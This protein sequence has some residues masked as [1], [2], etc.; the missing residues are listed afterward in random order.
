MYLDLAELDQVFANRWLW[1]AR[2]PAV[3]WFRR[4]DHLGERSTTLDESV[5]QFVET[6]TG[7]RPT[8]P[9]RLLTHLRTFGYVIN[10]ISFYYCFDA[11]GQQ[12]R[13]IVAQVDNTPWGERHCYV[14][15]EANSTTTG[16]QRLHRQTKEFHV[17]PFM[18]M[19]I[20]Y[21]WRLTMPGRQ[22]TAH[23]ENFS[24]GEKL[25][26]AT[27]LLKRREITGFN[28]ARVFCRFPL[29][30]G[31]VVAAIYWQALRLWWK[32]CPYFP[33]PKSSTKN[34]RVNP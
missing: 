13:T 23:I 27:L 32:K 2:G 31:Q 22:L 7:R 12:V 20:E 8:G 19:E 34:E 29:M 18:P 14:L 25:F 1:S 21:R 4:E 30:T 6:Q 9:I 28:L 24:H 15:D 3:S 17:S 5:R 26:D 10:P 11:D 16:S 33:H